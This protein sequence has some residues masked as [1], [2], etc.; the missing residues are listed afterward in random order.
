MPTELHHS[1][2][3][4]LDEAIRADRAARGNLQV[5]D[6]GRGGLRI[7]AQRGFDEAFLQLFALVRPDEPSVCSRAFRHSRR[8]AVADVRSDP[9]FAPYLSMA[10]RAGFWAV[11]S[12]PILGAAGDVIGVLST[13][14]DRV[15]SLS[16]AAGEALDECTEKAARVLQR[17]ADVSRTA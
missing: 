17:S 11:Q 3:D 12:S 5:Y 9:F 8:V 6:A 4:I 2:L 7:V 13:H 15:H 16:K 1:L 14:F 10:R